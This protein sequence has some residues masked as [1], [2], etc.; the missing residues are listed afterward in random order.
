MIFMS[1]FDFESDFCPEGFN[2]IDEGV[3]FKHYGTDML[4]EELPL[5][6]TEAN[7]F[8][9]F[10]EK[11]LLWQKQIDLNGDSIAL[12]SIIEGS[13][14]KEAVDQ[15]RIMKECT[16]RG[17]FQKHCGSSFDDFVEILNINLSDDIKNT[18][19]VE[20]TSNVGLA[21]LTEC[22]ESDGEV[23]C[24]VN[25][26][27]LDYDGKYNFR[28]LNSDGFVHV[29]GISFSDTDG[30]Y[31]IINDVEKEYGAGRKIALDKFLKAWSTSDYT[32]ITVAR[33]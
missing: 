20:A 21:E 23:I 15:N 22:V 17:L 27:L 24:Y 7:S 9:R 3:Y 4:D 32:A 12:K 33:R 10:E 26:M 19:A 31:A 8:G 16:D 2:E 6:E 13:L 30:D 25:K 18:F 28:G 5:K 14:K 29:I 1:S 11:A